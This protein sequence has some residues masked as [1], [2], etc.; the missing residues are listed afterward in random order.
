MAS[1]LP[2]LGATRKWPITRHCLTKRWKGGSQENKAGTENATYG[3]RE[4]WTPTPPSPYPSLPPYP[5]LSLSPQ[6]PDNV[7]LCMLRNSFTC[8]IL[9]MM[10]CTRKVHFTLKITQLFG[11]LPHQMLLSV[12]KTVW[13]TLVNYLLQ[14]HYQFSAREERFLFI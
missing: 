11:I 8:F 4:I 12:H 1:R 7:L 2:C 6:P 9:Y 10:S 14:Q 13:S 5:S 3:R